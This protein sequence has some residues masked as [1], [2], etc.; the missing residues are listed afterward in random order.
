MKLRYAP[1]RLVRQLAL[2]LGM[3]TFLVFL[4]LQPLPVSAD[5]SSFVRIINASPDAATVDVFVDGAKL[6][7]NNDFATVTD[8]LQLPPGRHK[9]QAALIGKGIGAAIISQTLSVRAG[10]AY[11]V[12]A[13][14]TR[15]TGFR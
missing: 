10:I 14:G 15:A 9:V 11:T 13:L 4:G 8:Y 1:A 6:V 2:L 12:A 5:S 7:G 3:L